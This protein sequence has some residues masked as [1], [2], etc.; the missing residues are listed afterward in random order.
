[1]PDVVDTAINAGTFAT[2]V[3]AL[4]V[5]GL[6]EG[7]KAEGPFT[8]FAPTDEAFSKL[9]SGTVE[10]LLENIPDLIKVLTYHVI[11]DQKITAAEIGK[12]DSVTT[13]EGSTL[14]INTSDGVKVNDAKVVT[15]DVEADNGVIHIIDTVL[16]PE[17]LG[18]IEPVS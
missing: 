10:A 9:P 3:T 7:L 18:K 6:A 11:P 8:V 2:L 15:P 5:A 13:S 17:S 16:I 12:T 1:M 4:N 14:K